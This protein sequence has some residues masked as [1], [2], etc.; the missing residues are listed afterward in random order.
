MRNITGTA[1]PPITSPRRQWKIRLVQSFLWGI[2][3]WASVFFVLFGIYWGGAF[4]API[5]MHLG[6]TGS[7]N[8]IYSIYGLLCHQMAQRSLFLFGPQVMYNVDQ[9]PIH[10]SGNP[11]IDTLT[12]RAFIGSSEMGWKVAWSDRMVY[13]YGGV[14]LAGIIYILLRHQRPRQPVNWI[15]FGLLM[16]P[17]A[18]DGISHFLSDVSGGLLD[19]FRYEN[20]W[21]ANLTGNI[22]PHWFY[23]GDAFGSF[24]SWMRLIS[25]LAFG[26]AIVGIAFPYLDRL[27]QDT[28]EL[29]RLK[30]AKI[31]PMAQRKHAK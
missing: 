5:F 25:G 28:A 1:F 30:L 22:F 18:V 4:L 12:L 23:A 13:M 24:N 11:A 19:G 16:L 3:H 27:T 21:L 6:W 17:M 7:A 2:D 14:L 8:F 29:L 31:C 26:F 20:G 15:T 9:L 10:L